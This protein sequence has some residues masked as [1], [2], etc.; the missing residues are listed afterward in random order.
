[1]PAK[2]TQSTELPVCA[3]NKGVDT[4]VKEWIFYMDF[5]EWVFDT[6]FRVGF[7]LPDNSSGGGSDLPMQQKPACN[8]IKP[9]GLAELTEWV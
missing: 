9:C 5:N 8:P 3:P 1:M 6:G 7:P 2:L 4:G